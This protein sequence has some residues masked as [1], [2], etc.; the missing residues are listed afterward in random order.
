MNNFCS[1]YFRTW[2]CKFLILMR[3]RTRKLLLF[4]SR[5]HSREFWLWGVDRG[6]LV[7]IAHGSSLVQCASSSTHGLSLPLLGCSSNM[8]KI[9]PQ[10]HTHSPSSPLVLSTHRVRANTARSNSAQAEPHLMEKRKNAGL[11]NCPL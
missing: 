7:T 5:G 6:G 3:N 10:H 8:E 4:L 1:P 2:T 11:P 9:G